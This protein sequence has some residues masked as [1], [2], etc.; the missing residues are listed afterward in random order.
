MLL[1]GNVEDNHL[2]AVFPYIDNI[3]IG[4]KD[5]ADHDTNLKLFQKAAQRANLKF[6]DSKSVF[7][8]QRLPLLGY[9][10][11][12]GCISPDPERLRPLLELPLP[13]NSKSPNRC[14]VLFSY[15]SQWVPNHLRNEPITSCKSF[16]LS[17]KAEKAFEDL[18]S[19]IAKAAVYAIDDSV[20]F[21]VETDASDVAI[22]ATLNQKG[23]PVAFFSHALQESELKHSAIEKEAQ[24]IFESIRH[25]RHFLIGSHFTLKPD[26]KSVSYMFNQHH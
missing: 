20:L 2:K 17:S 15:Y 26:Q 4:G 25:W 5:Q 6:N 7:S 3:T 22:A 18:K 11:E 8:T 21:E 16:P 1:K 14:L 24:A 9:F 23:R 13:Q 10:I 19:I 12:N